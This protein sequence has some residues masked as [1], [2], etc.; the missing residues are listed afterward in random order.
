MKDKIRFVHASDIHLGAN[1]YAISERFADMGK[2]FSE[3]VNYT[4]ETN[5]DFLV[6]AGDL[7]DKKNIN[8]KTLTLCLDIIKPLKEKNIPIYVTEG[9]HDQRTYVNNYSWLE[10]LNDN[11]YINLLNPVKNDI[12]DDYD[13][14]LYEERKDDE[15]NIKK[16]GS[17]IITDD[18]IIYGLGFPGIMPDKYLDC[19]TSKYIDNEGKVVI[20]M[21]HS[22]IDHFVTEGMGGLR[23]GF[24]DDLVNKSDYIA[25]GHIHNRY[26]NPDKKYFNPGSLENTSVPQEVYDK[27]FYDVTIDTATKKVDYKFIKVNN[28]KIYNITANIDGAENQK[29]AY[30]LILNKVEGI[31]KTDNV[32]KED[33]PII[34]IKVKGEIKDGTSN[35]NLNELKDELKEKYN[36]LYIEI[37]NLIKAKRFSDN[38]EDESLTRD[39]IDRLVIK[40]LLKEKGFTD[41]ESKDLLDIVLTMKELSINGDVD[42]K[43]EDG[44]NLKEKILEFVKNKKLNEKDIDEVVDAS[45]KL[46]LLD[47]VK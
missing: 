1:P 34:S 45:E 40:N 42:S 27:G 9:N 43:T 39:D 5:A 47:E 12:N 44:K 10:L 25:L 4:L 17:Y 32:T 3:V 29:E 15:G 33:M 18:A 21:L 13:L 37:Q 38:L 7:F 46:E 30:D 6:L 28:R 31:F 41:D 19:M 22:G 35:I 2:V 26:E 20:S 23:E 24:I 36:L 14:V 8:A 16:Y 11:G